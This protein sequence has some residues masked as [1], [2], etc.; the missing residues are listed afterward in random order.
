M[1]GNYSDQ[2]LTTYYLWNKK[3]MENL[4]KLKVMI[5]NGLIAVLKTLE[6][7]KIKIVKIIMPIQIMMYPL[8]I[9]V[10][11]II[12]KMQKEYWMLL[13]KQPTLHLILR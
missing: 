4:L 3:L 12:L 5:L 13:F 8:M 2:M 9:Q 1:D 7:Y 10:K 6:A 11:P